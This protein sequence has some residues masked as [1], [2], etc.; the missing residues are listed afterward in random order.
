[1]SIVKPITNNISIRIVDTNLL[2]TVYKVRTHAGELIIHSPVP[3]ASLAE[4]A[5]EC[6]HKLLK[7]VRTH[8]T[9]K[10]SK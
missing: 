6:Q 1:M 4:E 5:A 2:V 9:R 10:R 7:K 3:L 8:H